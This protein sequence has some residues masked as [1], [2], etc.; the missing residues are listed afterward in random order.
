[1]IR[2]ATMADA[3]AVAAIW[4]H[5]IRETVATFNSVKK[6]GAEVAALITARQGQRCFLVAEDQGRLQGFATYDQFRGGVGYSHSMEHTV[7]LAPDAGGHGLGGALMA[8]V[9][10][11]ATTAGAHVMVAAVTAENAAGRAFHAKLGYIQVGEMQ[12]VGRKF[13]RWMNLVLMQKILA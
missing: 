2:D 7:L 4:N 1:M 5:H 10:A 11:H 13:D 8:A 3:G 12:Q 6:T 9:E